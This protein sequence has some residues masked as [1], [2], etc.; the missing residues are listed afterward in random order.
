M[1]TGLG[2]S[3]LA[4]PPSEHNL[5]RWGR[6]SN[7][8]RLRADHGRP[9]KR[10][11]AGPGWL[12]F[13]TLAGDDNPPP[14]AAIIVHYNNN[15][16]AAAAT[17]RCARWRRPREDGKLQEQRQLRRKEGVAEPALGPAG[18]C[19]RP[20]C[21]PSVLPQKRRVFMCSSALW[22]S[23]LWSSSSSSSFLGTMMFLSGV[24]SPKRRVFMCSSALWSSALWSSSSSS[25][26]LGT[27]MFLSGVHG[28]VAG[29]GP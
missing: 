23:A 2:P 10:A 14:D 19:E 16:T 6:F 13:V 26:F 22:S 21:E 17:V 12:K 11:R 8:S 3:A 25:S 5:P 1:L 24:H 29:R 27:T 9:G 18:A 28:P 4:S 20:F 7:R 15:T